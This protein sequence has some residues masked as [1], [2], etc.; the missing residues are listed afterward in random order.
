M[1]KLNKAT[2]EHIV[3][4]AVDKLY[5]EK[6]KAAEDELALAITKEVAEM[7]RKLRVPEGELAKYKDFVTFSDRWDF[8]FSHDFDSYSYWRNRG[9]ANPTGMHLSRTFPCFQRDS[10]VRVPKKYS[11]PFIKVI[12]PY[13]D[14]AERRNALRS[15]LTLA[16]EGI[17]TEKMLR[18]NYPELAAYLPGPEK[19]KSSNASYDALKDELKALS[20]PKV[21]ASKK[22]KGK[23]NAG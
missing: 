11:E 13:R 18:E 5:A 14:L 3:T 1:G 21:E 8:S 16:L 17:T 22:V 20:L 6:M 7:Y 10:G 12:T 23:K 2:K 15:S 9:A 19:G 4:S